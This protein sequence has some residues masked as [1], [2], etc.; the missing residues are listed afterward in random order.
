MKKPKGSKQVEAPAVPPLLLRQ[1]ELNDAAHGALKLLFCSFD[2]EVWNEGRCGVRLFELVDV[3]A[4][5][6]ESAPAAA[7][8]TVDIDPETV[9]LRHYVVNPGLPTRFVTG[10]LICGIADRLRAAGAGSLLVA[11]P[12]DIE[13]IGELWTTGFRKSL[14]EGEWLELSL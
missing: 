4:G 12:D 7:A 2:A 13:R 6:D 11:A 10:R 9:E 5:G 3:A 8:L 1:V 14:A